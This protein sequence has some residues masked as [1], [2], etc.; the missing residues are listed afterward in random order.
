MKRFL[1]LLTIVIVFISCND[2]D[3]NV[4]I[5]IPPVSQ[6]PAET[7]IGAN[8]FGCLIDGQVFLP[9]YSSNSY[10][11]F[12]QL[13]DG[14][15][16]F[17]VNANNKKVSILTSIALGTMNLQISQ[18][19]TYNLSEKI[20]GNAFGSYFIGDDNTGIIN[21]FETSKINGGQLRITKLDFTL[22]IVSGTFWYDIKDNQNVVHQIREGRFDMQFTQ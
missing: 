4:A 19:Q 21:I 11:C 2:S 16:L 3:D 9:G 12:Y 14:G 7:Q 1:L 8:T 22:N 17:N 20:D 18:G 13:I 15:Y 5:V 10:Q 6:L